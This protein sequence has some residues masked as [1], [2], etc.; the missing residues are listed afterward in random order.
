M[1]LSRHGVAGVAASTAIIK[2][3]KRSE[4]FNPLSKLPQQAVQSNKVYQPK[5]VFMVTSSINAR[6]I[7]ANR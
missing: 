1:R 7:D 5:E 2:R 4:A 3:N 6:R